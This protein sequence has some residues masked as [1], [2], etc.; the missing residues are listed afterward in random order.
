MPDRRIPD[1][2]P[3]V[4]S[5]LPPAALSDV[6][7]AKA[8]APSAKKS[9]R[10]GAGEAAASLSPTPDPTLPSAKPR[11]RKPA[12]A[13]SQRVLAAT[14]ATAVSEDERRGMIA[15]AAYLRAESRGFA[16]GGEAEDW[17]AAEKEIDALLSNTASAPQ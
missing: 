15:L 11:K 13:K 1:S 3:A 12:A 6:K 5:P 9:A 2:Q 4:R 17:I 8:A 14:P 7:T 16:P 10:S